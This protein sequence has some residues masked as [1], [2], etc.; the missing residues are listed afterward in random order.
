MFD[1]SA[2]LVGLLKTQNIWTERT[3]YGWCPFPTTLNYYVVP[4][5]LIETTK[6]TRII[7]IL[8]ARVTQSYPQIVYT[9]EPVM[10]SVLGELLNGVLSGIRFSW[11]SLIRL[12]IISSIRQIRTRQIK[13]RCIY[14]NILETLLRC[15]NTDY[16]ILMLLKLYPTY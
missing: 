2:K 11:T 5:F 13:L 14:V 16:T 7:Q 9:R 6:C 15:C 8:R 10:Y 4:M 3:L 12:F 1:L